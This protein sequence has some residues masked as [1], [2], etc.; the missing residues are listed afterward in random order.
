MV[1]MAHIARWR[2]DSPLER[3]L[4]NRADASEFWKGLYVRYYAIKEPD[5]YRG[6]LRMIDACLAKF[7]L[8]DVSERKRAFYI[9]DMVYS[10]H[11]FGFM[12]DEYFWYELENL[13]ARG[14]AEFISDKIRYS[15]YDACNDLQGSLSL[16]NKWTTY[17]LLSEYFGRECLLIR[18]ADDM[19][20]LADFCERH[21]GF[22]AKP[23]DGNCGQGTLLCRSGGDGWRGPLVSLLDQ[24]EVVVE[25][26]IKQDDRLAAFH[27]ESV[28]TIRMPVIIDTEG[29]AHLLG[30]FFRMGRGD[31]FLDNAGRGGV[32]AA[33]DPES[34]VCVSVV[35]ECARRYIRHPD[36][37]LVVLGFEIPRWREAV[38]LA[39]NL[40]RKMKGVRYVGWDFALT[41][42]GWVV[43]E[44]NCRA[45]FVSQIA[46]REGLLRDF[47]HYSLGDDTV[48]FV[49]KYSQLSALE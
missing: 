15:L 14:R 49:S 38:A 33:L 40:A 39:K 27:P 17:Q 30:P 25:E 20:A 7:G 46:T 41:P 21:E 18:S 9:R 5:Y 19:D 31:S 13:N 3:W 37:G 23:I 44:G 8:S 36:T 11:R 4:G 1:S 12:F 42:Q 48:S 22:I 28:N 43:V 10:L 35:D 47:I 16:T 6:G 2:I 45:Q 34:G 32:F 24:G 26:I 29:E